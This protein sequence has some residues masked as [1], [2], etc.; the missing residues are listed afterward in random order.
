[1]AT[2][3][4]GGQATSAK[5]PTTF[6]QKSLATDAPV[7]GEAMHA[8]VR[9]AGLDHVLRLLSDGQRRALAS[10][11]PAPP[12]DPTV[13]PGVMHPLLTWIRLRAPKERISEHADFSEC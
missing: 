4:S 9:Q 8:V 6:H 7:V 3:V 1:M 11:G 5:G 2:G 13:Q 12:R 10:T